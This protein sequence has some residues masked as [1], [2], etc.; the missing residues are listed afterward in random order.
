MRVT[1]SFS[2]SRGRDHFEWKERLAF[3]RRGIECEAEE[4]ESVVIVVVVEDDDA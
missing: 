1:L 3:C 2:K 4:S